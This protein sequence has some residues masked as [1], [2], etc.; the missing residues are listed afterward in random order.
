MLIENGADPDLPCGKVPPN[1]ICLSNIFIT[2]AKKK[3]K[4][5][6]NDQN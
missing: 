6:Q 5:N 4:K 2:L 1:Y 3:T